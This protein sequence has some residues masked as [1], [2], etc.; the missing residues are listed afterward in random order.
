VEV[1]FG[2][3]RRF[4]DGDEGGEMDD[5]V[6]LLGSHEADELRTV[7]ERADV[8]NLGRN[9]GSVAFGEIVDHDNVK[10]LGS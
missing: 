7:K 5:G 6:D 2:L 9:A 4:A 10:S 8:E 3:T 1:L